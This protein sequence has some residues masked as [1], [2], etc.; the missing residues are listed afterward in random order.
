MAKNVVF[1]CCPSSFDRE[2]LDS[3]EDVFQLLFL[4]PENQTVEA[5]ETNSID[6]EDLNSHL[7]AG[8]SVFISPKKQTQRSTSNLDEDLKQSTYFKRI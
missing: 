4:H 6:F 7:R 2:E 1:S 3:D 5:W 8:E